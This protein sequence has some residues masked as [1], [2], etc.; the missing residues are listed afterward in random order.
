MS[1]SFS[2][3]A[4]AAADTVNYFPIHLEMYP[5]WQDR[6]DGAWLYV[7]QA[8]ETSLERPYRQ[9]V[10]RL[11]EEENGVI[12]STVYTL[13]EPLDRFIQVHDNPVIFETITPDSLSLRNGCAIFLT[14]NEDGSFTGSTIG[15]DCVSTL[16]G[17]THASSEVTVTDSL[18]TS[19]DRGWDDDGNQIWGV[20]TG[21]YQFMKVTDF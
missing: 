10:Y 1:G 12:S 6:T 2:S 20:T 18:L 7:E 21:G 14:R 3:A 19:W 16:H 11:A 4:Q 13:P 9:R 8:V 15:T 5:I 17:A